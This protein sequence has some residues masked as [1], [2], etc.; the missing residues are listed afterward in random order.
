MEKDK[1]PPWEQLKNQV[2]LGD[3]EF[4]KKMQAKIDVKADLTEIPLAQKRPIAKP[5]SY[6][7]GRHKDRDNA[8]VAAYSTGA[9]S[10]KEIG[11]YV[12]LHYSRV[13]RIV[14]KAK[15]KT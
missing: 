13:S 1:R 4:V 6:Y 15:N 9:Y 7:I 2:Y 12:G 3:E 5:L 8:I 11:D 14:R 10:M